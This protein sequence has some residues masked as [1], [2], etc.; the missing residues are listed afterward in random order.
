MTNEGVD[1]IDIN[2]DPQDD[3]MKH[4]LQCVFF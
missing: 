2:T 4:S 1:I 3:I